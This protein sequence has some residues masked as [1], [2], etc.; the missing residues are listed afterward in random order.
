MASAIEAPVVAMHSTDDPAIPYGELPRL[1]EL[2]PHARLI[3]LDRFE[4]V[5][6]ELDSPRDLLRA[7]GDLLA[8]WRFA[9]HVLSAQEG[10][11]PRV[12]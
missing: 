6:L 10:W 4:H 8:V 5:D 11:L 12:R 1:G 7:G 2:V 3:T 9:T